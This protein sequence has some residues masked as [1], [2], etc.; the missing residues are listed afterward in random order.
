MRHMGD[1]DSAPPV[2]FVP[3]TATIPSGADTDDDEFR[4]HAYE[5]G[6]DCVNQGGAAQT[7]VIAPPA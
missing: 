7:S 1:P 3:V 2:H 5:L 6:L 4:Q